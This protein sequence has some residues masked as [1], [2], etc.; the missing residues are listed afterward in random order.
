MEKQV[1]QLT[2][3]LQSK[4]KE[5]G[6]DG[7]LVGV[8]GG[9]DSAVVSFL[10]KRAFPEQSLGVL[11]PIN[12]KVEDQSDALAVVEKAGLDY[13]GIELTKPYKETFSAVK[14]SLVEKGDWNDSKSQLGGAN[15][16]ARLRMSTLYTVANNYNYLVIGTDNAAED[17]TGYF[18]KYGDGGVDLVPL[19]HMRKEQV[20]QM[21]EALGIPDSVLHKQPS[22]E[23]WEGQSDEEELG[24]SYDTIDAF[25]KGEQVDTEDEKKL[26]ELHSKTEHK[27]QVPAGPDL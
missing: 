22:A 7:A 4:V 20:R 3:W 15:L 12:K 5:A 26:K 17:Y 19:I 23:L 8:S 10:I 13:I 6:A 24:L 11:M 2:K 16:Q 9:I 18:T 21:G 1:E 25:L 14:D 27:R